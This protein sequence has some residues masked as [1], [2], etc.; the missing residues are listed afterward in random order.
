MR[1]ESTQ[2]MELQFIPA[3][4]RK[5]QSVLQTLRCT[6]YYNL[7]PQG[8]GNIY[9]RCVKAFCLCITI[10]P[11]K[12]TETQIMF[13]PIY[14]MDITIY[15]RKG[16]ETSSFCRQTQPCVIT[17]YPRKGTETQRLQRSAPYPAII[18]YPR[19]GTETQRR[20]SAYQRS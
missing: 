2:T 17:I 19:K 13:K 20:L 1:I 10:Y 7:S 18:I 16:T 9:F 4:G 12:G 8:D 11:R 3:R 6:A 14:E 15:P 5:H